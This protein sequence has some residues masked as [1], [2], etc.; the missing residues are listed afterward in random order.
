M[1]IRSQQILRKI[2]AG[3]FILLLLL[4]LTD[5]FRVRASYG[6]INDNLEYNNEVYQIITVEVRPAVMHPELNKENYFEV[7]NILSNNKAYPYLQGKDIYLD[8]SSSLQDQIE[9]AKEFIVTGRV[10]TNNY[11]ML[12]MEVTKVDEVN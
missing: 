5:Y 2:G 12:K 7:L 10:I 11:G 1:S 6:E 4:F 8:F 9:G 3:F